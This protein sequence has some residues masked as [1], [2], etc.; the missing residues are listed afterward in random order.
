MCICVYMVMFTNSYTCI[1]MCSCIR[2]CICVFVYICLFSR[3]RTPAYLGVHVFIYECTRVCAYMYSRVNRRQRDVAFYRHTRTHRA[4]ARIYIC[5]C[6]TKRGC[7]FAGVSVLKFASTG[8]PLS[9]RTALS[10]TI[11]IE[12][13]RVF[14]QEQSVV[15]SHAPIIGPLASR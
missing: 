5:V 3:I 10:F 14:R 1:F 2:I 15:C 4:R 7:F 12:N 9:V 11:E 13:Q 8:R 6:K